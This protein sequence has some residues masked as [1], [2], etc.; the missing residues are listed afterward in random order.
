M[1]EFSLVNNVLRAGDCCMGPIR[2]RFVAD[3]GVSIA[4]RARDA[5]R[6]FTPRAVCRPNARPIGCG[7]CVGVRR[8]RDTGDSRT[9]GREASAFQRSGPGA[10][11]LTKSKILPSASPNVSRFGLS[12][13]YGSKV[14]STKK[15]PVVSVHARVVYG[16]ADLCAV[17]R[18][19]FAVLNA[20]TVCSCKQHLG[21]DA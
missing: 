21:V 18:P 9:S 14:P 3:C 5:V 20:R 13:F 4:R 7:G 17:E 11:K 2:A 10:S 1:C 16:V 15:K 8:T 19:D 6:I 12:V